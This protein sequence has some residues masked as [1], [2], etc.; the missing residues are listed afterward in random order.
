MKK[1]FITFVV[2]GLFAAGTAYA[3]VP[4]NPAEQSATPGT[5]YHAVAQ[6]PSERSRV[7]GL[8]SSGVPVMPTIDSVPVGYQGTLGN[9]P[10]GPDDKPMGVQPEPQKT[11]CKVNGEYVPCE[12]FSGYAKMGLK[13]LLGL[14]L[15]GFVC[16][17]FWL[18]M[19]IHAIQNPIEHKAIWI[20]CFIVFGVVTA[21]VYYFAVKRTFVAPL[22]TP[23]PSSPIPPLA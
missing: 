16:F 9:P 6:A 14:T 1:I 21:I 5:N 8:P 10:L 19:L 2:V 7:D 20:V 22:S 4:I 13:I 12:Q 11:N 15:L 17:V 3:I 23:L 18:L